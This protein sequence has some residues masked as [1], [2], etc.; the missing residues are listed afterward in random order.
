MTPSLRCSLPLLLLVSSGCTFGRWERERSVEASSRVVVELES[1]T[2]EDG[3]M[4]S[5]FAHPVDLEPEVMLGL[6]QRLKYKPS[7]R[8]DD[9]VAVFA[10][11]PIGLFARALSNALSLAGPTQRV[12]FAV[13]NPDRVLFLP[14]SNLTRGV[15]FVEPAGV[16]NLA[17][18]LID[19]GDDELEYGE[20]ANPVFRSRSDAVLVLPPEVRHYVEPD[21]NE[22]RTWVTMDLA[23]VAGDAVADAATEDG[24]EDLVTEPS[25]VVTDAAA[26]PTTPGDEREIKLRF[27]E[28][29][30]REGLIAERAYQDK[31]KE[32]EQR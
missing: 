23:E 11:V 17:F 5:G 16:L 10:E 18:D 2:G 31:R 22:R 27:L 14:T 15:A 4:T 8:S 19:S 13:L 20:W 30:Y 29:L 3:E 26:T 9:L 28:Q 7:R 24:P 25:D 21:G 1:W 32:L 12:R 6:L